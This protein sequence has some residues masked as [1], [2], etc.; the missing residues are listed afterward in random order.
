MWGVYTKGG[1]SEG[2]S[3]FVNQANKTYAIN[4]G[5]S[6]TPTT[7]TI[8]MN[9]TKTAS[10]RNGKWRTDNSRVYQGQWDGNGNHTGYIRYSDTDIATLQGKTITKATLTIKRYTGGG[11]I[12]SKSDGLRLRY[13]KGEI[14]G[15]NAIPDVLGSELIITRPAQGQSLTVDITNWIKTII[16]QGTNTFSGL[17]F[18]TSSTSNDYY[19]ILEDL[20]HCSYSLSVTYQ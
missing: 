10:A 13:F 4:I 9:A 3:S 16:N 17:C 1:I 20:A 12:A 8:T 11:T 19:C 5:G 6:T 14:G 18:Y 7:K 15:A 2:T